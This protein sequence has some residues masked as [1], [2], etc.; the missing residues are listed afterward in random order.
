MR[1]RDT[2]I[3]AFRSVSANKSRAMLTM[4]GI[5]IGVG[6]V[7]LMSAIGASM[8]GVILSQISSL[9]TQS[10]IIFPGQ[11]EGRSAGAGSD[12]LTFSDLD[13]LRQLKTITSVSP[14]IF[15]PGKVSFGSQEGNPQVLGI[16]ME[17]FN[18]TELS[19]TSG[20]MLESDDI[21]G[22]SKVAMIGPEVA[23]KFFG[24]TNPIGKRIKV[25]N[26]H[27]TVI[28]VTKA[29]GS[30]FFQSADNR[31]YVPFAVA[32]DV[33]KQPYLNYVTMLAT[34]KFDIAFDDVKYLLRRTHRIDN[35]TDD[36]KKDD[37]VIRSSEQ[38]SQ[39]LGGVS[40]GL[41]MFITTIATISLIVGGIGIMNIM[42]VSVTERTREIGLR[43][44]VGAK[45][46]DVLRQFLIESV[47][48]TSI[49]GII[50]MVLGV[51]FAYVAAMV[52]RN[53]LGTYT[54]AISVP[55]M[56]AAFL[57]AA[58]TGLVF[59]ITPAKRAANLHPIEALR[60][61]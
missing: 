59:G 50:G 18:N 36:E 12:S 4:L 30:Q 47:L 52:V 24:Q 60:Y 54:F 51:G 45:S 56:I 22:A 19:V 9:G 27:F 61:E 29:L 14:V 6:A 46:A 21:D 53:F 38:A 32:K 17:Y 11:Q 37:F 43:K 42:L 15:I 8:K 40:L 5:I 3:I 58:I 33:T 20:R 23:D 16:T 10:M 13:Q 55:S 44:A 39:I 1:L 26:D 2:F 28:G 34:G 49:G 31:I 41:T 25:G 35:P 48:L 7:V 57:M